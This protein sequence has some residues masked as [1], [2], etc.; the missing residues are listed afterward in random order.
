MNQPLNK[1]P[2]NLRDEEKK[3]RQ[4]GISTWEE[5]KNLDD[6]EINVL[7]E[8]S[9]CTVQNFNRLRGMA[10]IICEI[11]ISQKDAALLMHSGVASLKALAGL[12]PEQLV[13]QTG[14]LER[15]LISGNKPSLELAEAHYLIQQA[16]KRQILN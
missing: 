15:Q 9:L 1:L 4:K 6:E 16:K 11:Q 12:T 7:A 10:S 13:R 14:R 3:L 5:I 2:K 8:N